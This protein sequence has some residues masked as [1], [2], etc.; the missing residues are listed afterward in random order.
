MDY[1]AHESNVINDY[2]RLLHKAFRGHKP[3]ECLL[4][5]AEFIDRVAVDDEL[6]TEESESVEATHNFIILR[7]E[8]ASKEKSEK[9]ARKATKNIAKN[10]VGKRAARRLQG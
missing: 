1:F 5:S 9:A 10:D 7:I 6:T 2:M 4:S 8:V 3:I